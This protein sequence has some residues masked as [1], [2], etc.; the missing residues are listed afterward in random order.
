L[1]GEKRAR[2]LSMHFTREEKNILITILAAAILGIIINIFT[3]Y[4]A[5][6][7]KAHEIN[8]PVLIN[9]NSATAEELDALPGIGKVT[10]KRI[11]EYR[12]SHGNFGD[13]EKL[14]E[15]KG[16]TSKKLDGLKRYI[17]L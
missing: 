8:D 13:I 10:A 7:R 12:Q 2:V 4:G 6:Q 17:T 1:T 3:T 9:I 15:V 5:E 14:K 11:V 16:I